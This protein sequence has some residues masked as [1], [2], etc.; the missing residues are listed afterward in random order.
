MGPKTV[1]LVSHKS[2]K[3]SAVFGP[4]HVQKVVDRQGKERLEIDLKVEYEGDLDILLEAG[5]GICVGIR[6][7]AFAGILHVVI[8]PILDVLPIVGTVQIYFAAL[9][10]INWNFEGNF[11]QI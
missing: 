5:A 8:T 2:S 3:I 11:F 10:E 6:K 9:P 4:I 7:V 1:K